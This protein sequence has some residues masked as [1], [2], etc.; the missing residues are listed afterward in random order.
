MEINFGVWVGLSGYSG[1]CTD[2]SSCVA[3]GVKWNDGT[4]LADSQS[5][6]TFKYLKA[7]ECA[8][9]DGNELK[10]N[11]CTGHYMNAVCEEKPKVATKNFLDGVTDDINEYAGAEGKCQDAGGTLA[12][13]T[14][15]E[16]FVASGGKFRN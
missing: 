12:R 5:F 4:P 2:H 16:D 3:L 10:S 1:S 8:F 7:G 9:L 11:P 15:V 13:F 14:R 6:L